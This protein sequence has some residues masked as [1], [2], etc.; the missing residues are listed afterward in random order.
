MKRMKWVWCASLLMICL[1]SPELKAREREAEVLH[2]RYDCDTP[3]IAFSKVHVIDKRA[4]GQVLGYVQ[5][6][7]FNRQT[8]LVFEGNLADGLARYFQQERAI[9]RSEKELVVVL[10]AF[11]L[12]EW[13]GKSHEIGL[14]TVSLRCFAGGNG[15]GYSE[16]LT[17][18]STFITKGGNDITDKMLAMTSTYC[19]SIANSL[20][21]VPASS[22]DARV[23]TLAE[24]RQL[25]SLEM[26]QLPV[27]KEGPV[28]GIYGFYNSLRDN[29]PERPIEMSVEPGKDG[30]AHVALVMNKNGKKKL[31][32]L[33]ETWHYAVSDGQQ[34]AIYFNGEWYPL[35]MSANGFF[36]DSPAGVNNRNAI[37][38]GVTAGAFGGI[39]GAAIMSSTVSQ[40]MDGFRFRINPRT[41]RALPV[42]KIKK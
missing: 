39:V 14:M 41:G 4:E 25:D 1:C 15:S 32:K 42:M 2:L 18:D 19:C 38:V 37:S 8:E 10:E 35:Q 5:K 16:L 11:F 9:T 28:A 21:H 24:L 31:S 17:L 6:G 30:H 23:Y 12:S 26:Q 7:T 36:F 40:S 33:T 3:L 29:K 27:F 13:T 20:A 22:G 34:M